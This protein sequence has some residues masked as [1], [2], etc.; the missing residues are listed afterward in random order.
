MENYEKEAVERLIE[1]SEDFKQVYEDHHSYG[2]KIAKMEKKKHLTDEETI[3]V[4]RLKK[5][6]LSMKDVLETMLLENAAPRV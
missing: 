4:K 2:K 1:V 5:E 6:K 3:E